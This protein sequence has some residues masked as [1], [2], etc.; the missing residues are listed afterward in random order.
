M[1][2]RKLKC[3]TCGEHW[4]EPV[5]PGAR[6][7]ECPGCNPDAAKRREAER[8]RAARKAG[9]TVREDH[10]VDVPDFLKPVM[11]DVVRMA[12]DF[13]KPGREEL[14]AQVRKIAAARGHLELRRELEA[15]A[16]LC[17]NWAAWLPATQKVPQQHDE[18]A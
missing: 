4:E 13:P 16:A 14:A 2:T 17:A 12:A 18:A 11:Q 10:T 5:R 15:T 6:P 7:W 1:K 8:E 3:S 9:Q